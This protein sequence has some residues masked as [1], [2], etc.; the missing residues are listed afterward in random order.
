MENE[1]KN[2]EKPVVIKL[3]AA[4]P[5]RVVTPEF[6][7]ERPDTSA[8]QTS[9]TMLAGFVVT[10]ISVFLSFPP[11]V[12]SSVYYRWTLFFLSLS[13]FLFLLATEFYAFSGSTNELNRIFLFFDLGSFSYNVGIGSLAGGLILIFHSIGAIESLYITIVFVLLE[14]ILLA[15][16]IALAYKRMKKAKK[17]TKYRFD[18]WLSILSAIGMFCVFLSALYIIWLYG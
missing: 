4:A 1:A 13:A 8:W 11:Q 6:P 14:L 3:G 10:F 17:E 7:E 2:E 9:S 18:V 12:L 16:F 15:Y 5:S